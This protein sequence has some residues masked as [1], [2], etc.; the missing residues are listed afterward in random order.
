M[1]SIT[2][3]SI[4]KEARRRRLIGVMAIYVVGAWI[5]LQVADL[6]FPGWNIPDSAIRH[7]LIGT[8][9]LFPV[10]LVFGW[11]YDVTVQGVRRTP[12]ADS[13]AAGLLLAQRDYLELSL[14]ASI[15]AVVCFLVVSQVLDERDPSQFEV[16]AKDIP[17]NSIAVL[18]FVNMSDDASNEYFSDGISEQLLNELA[19]IPDLH[20][21]ARTSAFYYKDKNEMMDK[22][23][24]KLGVRTL[25]EGSVRKAGN[26]VRITAQLINASDG[27][28]LW[29]ETYDRELDDIFD[30]QDEI[31]RAIV[32]TLKIELL[33]QDLERLDR[34]ATSNVEAYDVYL[35]AM[36]Y[37]RSMASDAV[38]KSNELFQQAI[39]LAPD[40]ALAYDAL[41]YGY[42]LKTY[43]GSMS[44]DDG[45]EE[46]SI[47]LE[48]ALEL[49][50]DLEEAHASLGLLNDRLNRFVEANEHYETALAINPTYFGGHVNYGLSLVHQSRL[51]EA[52]AAYLRA[53]ALDP[54]NA[55]LNYNL[56]SLLMLMGEFNQGDD[57]IQK[58]LSI[59]P[60]RRTAKAA[61]THWLGVYGKLDEAVKNGQETVEAHPE[62]ST[63][64]AAL[65]RAYT[66]LGLNDEAKRILE[67]A[68]ESMPDDTRIRDA[69]T[70]FWLS[71]G[72]FES[73]NNFAEEDFKQLDAVAGDPMNYGDTQRVYRHG[74]S[75]LIR[76]EDQVA[77]DSFYW[78]AG[79][80]D[81][82][83]S[84]TYDY[85]G[86]LKMLSLAYRRL[87]RREDADILLSRCLELVELAREGGW[88]TPSLFVRLAEIYA[89]K[90]DTDEA[91]SNL[92]KAFEKGWRGLGTIEYGIFWQDLQ[93]DPGLNRI[94]VI[95]LDDL[96][97]QRKR[98][99]ERTRDA[100]QA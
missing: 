79:G 12:D 38:D 18:P 48:R 81:G 70:A 63:N 88:A 80:D 36:A 56:G 75:S 22:I 3:S 44:I 32:N 96:E 87:D 85:M 71:T 34:P 52:S 93:D 4:I 69:T 49:Q 55:N 43:N 98:L 11:H 53:Q 91:I 20:V 25:L 15:T 41:A 76:G 89:I 72:D 99:R 8:I 61:I 64:I 54:I 90:G 92:E 100:E 1:E 42:L 40:F 30:L 62:F 35:R 5:V 21:A 6:V 29:S 39:D 7:V 16:A 67:S 33:A 19:R 50:P 65:V 47:L 13:E 77:A 58:S 73:F 46:A 95:L 2:L 14:L 86:V 97:A 31:S 84:T 17:H 37:R 24:Q 23:G 82:I 27:Y 60:N 68:R 28:H 83:A 66:T 59:N 74:W 57:F 9:V 78:A 10:A 51:K 94:K 26:K 45:T